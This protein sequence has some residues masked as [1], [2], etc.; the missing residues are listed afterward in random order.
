MGSQ[1]RSATSTASERMIQAVHAEAR[2]ASAV[3]WDTPGDVFVWRARRCA[4]AVLYA[5]LHREGVDIDAIAKQRKGL[6]GLIE[7]KQ[8]EGTLTRETRAQLKALQEFGNIAAHYQLTG[9]VGEDSVDAMGRLLAALLREF[10]ATDGGAPPDGLRPYF[11]ALT[12]RQARIRSSAEIEGDRARQRVREL[13]A[14]LQSLEVQPR[15]NTG[16]TPR[17]RR[18]RSGVMLPGL[19]TVGGPGG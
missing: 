8:L 16:S 3:R 2:E 6:D 17:D 14:R 13:E 5:V 7:H 19:A 4:E 9:G 18:A 1:R 11:A 10:Y 15:A 12:D